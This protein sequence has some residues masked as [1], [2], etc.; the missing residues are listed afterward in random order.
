MDVFVIDPRFVFL[1]IICI[2][3]APQSL[4]HLNEVGCHIHI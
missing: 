3:L 4:G 1:F 2:L